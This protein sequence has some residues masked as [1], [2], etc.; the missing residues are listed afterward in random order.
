[1]AVTGILG[2]KVGMTRFF[3]EDGVNVPVTV[4]SAGPCFITQIKN[5]ESADGYNAIQIAYE[6]IKPGHSTLPNIGHDAKVGVSPKRHHRELRFDQGEEKEVANFTV[7]QEITVSDFE[8]IIYVDVVAT[9]KGK[10]FQGV[11]KR[12]NF[13]GLEA[14]HG[15]ER[16]HRSAGSIGGGG[17]NLGTGPKPKK[18]KRMAG[19]MGHVRV[20]VRN[21][22]IMKIIPEKNLFLLKGTV[23]GA[24]NG[25]V[26]V[27]TSKRPGKSKQLKVVAAA[28][29]DK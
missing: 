23:P 15:V 10:G 4:I 14:S 27:R 9:S 22:D 13:K 6:D 24:N 18:G 26:F 12:H 19:H 8:D 5:I 20:T 29:K 25:L 1:M 7:G 16:K 3:R 21:L 2:R 17:V 28:K 11:M